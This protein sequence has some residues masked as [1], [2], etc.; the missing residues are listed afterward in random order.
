MI[1]SRLHL[2]AVNTS[3]ERSAAATLALGAAACDAALSSYTSL[4]LLQVETSTP[5]SSAAEWSSG[6][7]RQAG[8]R[9]VLWS[10]K[11]AKQQLLESECGCV[12]VE[13]ANIESEPT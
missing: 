3:T 12:A 9:A 1:L 5:R 8:A 7:G 13:M 2:Q 10:C 6:S 4:A 11:S